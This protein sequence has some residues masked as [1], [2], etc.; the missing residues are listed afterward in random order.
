MAKSS[1]SSL[2]HPKFRLR[3]KSDIKTITLER[4]RG[5]FVRGEVGVGGGQVGGVIGEGA[6]GCVEALCGLGRDGE[7]AAKHITYFMQFKKLIL[8]N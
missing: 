3:G 1:L 4:V 5:S 6:G 2:A 8:T 7:R